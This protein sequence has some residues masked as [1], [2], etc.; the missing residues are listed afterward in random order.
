MPVSIFDSSTS[1]LSKH[2]AIEAYTHAMQ[3]HTLSQVS[4]LDLIEYRKI[5]ENHYD[6]IPTSGKSPQPIVPISIFNSSAGNYSAYNAMEAYTHSMQAHVLSQMAFLKSC[7]THG[8]ECKDSDDVPTSGVLYQGPGPPI[9]VEIEEA[10]AG[11]SATM[12]N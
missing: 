4:S 10:V 8:I 12:Q 3:T 7:K 9:A 6:G 5:S 1:N 11:Q 2:T